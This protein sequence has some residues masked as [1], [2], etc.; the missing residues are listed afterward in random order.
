MYQ[1]TTNELMCYLLYDKWVA[2]LKVLDFS[3]CGMRDITKNLFRSL[4]CLMCGYLVE[5]L[6]R[7][8]SW[9]G[10]YDIAGIEQFVF[11]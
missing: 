2:V 11:K 4:K 6:R 3:N 5:N 8:V 10:S 1:V 9:S 7:E